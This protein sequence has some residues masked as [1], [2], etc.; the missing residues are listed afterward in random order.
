MVVTID[1]LLIQEGFYDNQVESV[2]R[3]EAEG[4]V[5]IQFK[6]WL[7]WGDCDVKIPQMLVLYDP[8]TRYIKAYKIYGFDLQ[9][10]CDYIDQHGSFLWN[11]IIHYMTD[12]NYLPKTITLLTPYAMM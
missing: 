1:D 5:L 8:R 6:E 2:K 12:F 4:K 11:N 10:I 7:E 3:N 9:G